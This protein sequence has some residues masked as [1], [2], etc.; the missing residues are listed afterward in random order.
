M[1]KSQY[2]VKCLINNNQSTKILDFGMHPF[3]DTFI[4]NDQLLLSEPIFPLE[5][6]LDQ[7]SGLVQL[8]KISNDFARY[9]LYE[10]SYTS[11]NSNFAKNHWISYSEK[12]SNRF[13]LKNKFIVEI[14]SNDGFLLN[15]FSQISKV[16]GV[17]ASQEM[18]ALANKNGVFSINKI[19]NEE[20]S[21]YIKQN[22]DE[23]DVIIANNVF[24]HSND[25]VDFARGIH[26]LLRDEGVFVFEL[27]YWGDTYKSGKFDQ[28]YHEHITYFTVK[29]SFHLLK[30]ANLE[31][32]DIEFVN[33]HG[34][35]IRVY[36]KKSNDV[37]MSDMVSKLIDE[38]E[39]LGLFDINTYKKWQS[40]IQADR[41]KFLM[42]IHELKIQEPDSVIIGVGAAAKSNTL[43]NYYKLDN[44]IINFIT[45]SS[46]Y[47][48]NK[49]TPITR[50]PIVS[51]DI[52]ANYENVYALILS[53][54]IS[55]A[56]KET[57]NKINPSIKY[58]SL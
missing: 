10:Y 17:D 21:N 51:D 12:L 43:L 8:G 57:L 36:S 26:N 56:L 45:D 39:K 44:S 9:N 27:P 47:K 7:E 5:C 30:Q 38:E 19:F 34:G 11:S 37:Q 20:T 55:G 49:Y 16:L 50:I 14:G 35:S 1:I 52:F 48:Q 6:Y 54:N 53:W 41:S 46:E 25:P 4:K 22:Y 18:V 58:L 3:A 29:S 28:V 13:D 15:Q 32:F 24:N 40:V 23:A 31:I 42:M 33:Y 2:D